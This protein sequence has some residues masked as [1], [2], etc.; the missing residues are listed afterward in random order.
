MWH[1]VFIS[2][3]CLSIKYDW[4]HI[5]KN[6]SEYDRGTC[7][8]GNKS[9]EIYSPDPIWRLDKILSERMRNHKLL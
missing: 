8:H 4:K 3:N 7:E 9:N 6:N 1:W 5:L 2:C